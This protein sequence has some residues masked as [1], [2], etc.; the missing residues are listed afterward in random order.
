MNNNSPSPFW[1]SLNRLIFALGQAISRGGVPVQ[2][3][4]IEAM[5]RKVQE[6][7][8]AWNGPVPTPLVEE[9]ESL[10]EAVQSMDRDD[11][12]GSDKLL[13]RLN[14]AVPLIEMAA[15]RSPGDPTHDRWE[16]ESSI[17]KVVGRELEARSGVFERGEALN[18]SA[19]SALKRLGDLE[20]SLTRLRT[21]TANAVALMESSQRAALLSAEAEAKNLM[22][23]LHAYQVRA[24]EVLSHL[25]ES[26]AA[27][28][29]GEQAKRSAGS[30]KLWQ[31][32]TLASFIG[33]IVWVL[34]SYKVAQPSDLTLPLILSKFVGSIP[35]ALLSG[36]GAIQ[37][38]KS[39]AAEERNRQ[40]QLEIY[41][42]EPLLKGLE[43]SDQMSV[44]K[45]LISYFYRDERGQAQVGQDMSDKA[46]VDLIQKISALVGRRE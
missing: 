14:R 35:F 41:A 39:R 44:R 42:M 9:I 28:G 21:E 16:L 18:E 8:Y 40:A 11:L 31:L 6:S 25:I 13:E 5:L 19:E 10:C 4:A 46:S 2:L 38:S 27:G 26:G 22:A 17:A 32:M 23:Q 3:T 29:Y 24:K 43:A 33:W 20:G 30:R 12:A 15:V 45:H 37:V 1:L 34:T 7:P 36:F